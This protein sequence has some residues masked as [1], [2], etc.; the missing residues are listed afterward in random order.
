MLCL[1]PPE[2]G[3]KNEGE[4][5]SRTWTRGGLPGGAQ[6][7]GGGGGAVTQHVHIG[8]MCVQRGSVCA[9]TLYVCAF[10][11]YVY[12]LPSECL[13]GEVLAQAWV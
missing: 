1:S 9:F 5:P 3:R 13:A 8:N 12:V 10:T 6:A 4:V 2:L 11:L 7:A